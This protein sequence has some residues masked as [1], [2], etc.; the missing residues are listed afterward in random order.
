MYNVY[1]QVEQETYDDME[2]GEAAEVRFCFYIVLFTFLLDEISHAKYTK[3]V[4]I[5]FGLLH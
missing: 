4:G 2:V 3:F 1:L 5:T